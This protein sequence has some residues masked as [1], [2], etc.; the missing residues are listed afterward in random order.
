MLGRGGGVGGCGGRRGLETA[1]IATAQHNHVV[2]NNFSA[3]IFFAVVAFPASGLQISFNVNL[4]SLGKV[5]S[6]YFCQTAPGDNVM[7]LN[8][9][10]LVALVIFP[11][12][13]GGDRKISDGYSLGS[14][15]GLGVSRQASDNHCFV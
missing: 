1:F 4:S 10:L 6:T 14:G 9:F 7:V 2:G 13:V 8:S 5:L 15:S 11:N 12:S 3:V